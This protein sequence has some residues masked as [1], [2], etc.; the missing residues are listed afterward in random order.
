MAS[1]T[2]SESD[3][4]GSTLTSTEP[5]LVIDGILYWMW[6]VVMGLLPVTQNEGTRGVSN[7]LMYCQSRLVWES[8]MWSD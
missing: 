3:G 6:R 7:C 8:T 1:G 4:H 5:A 2:N